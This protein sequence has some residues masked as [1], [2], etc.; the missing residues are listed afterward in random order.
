M[1]SR[2][3][4]P[5]NAELPFHRGPDSALPSTA[6]TTGV[7]PA[8][9]HGCS[10]QVGVGFVPAAHTAEV[11]AVSAGGVDKPAGRTRLA[12]VRG[13]DFDQASA[14][15]LQL[16]AEHGAERRPSGA[17]DLAPESAAHHSLD[18]QL[19]DDHDAVALGVAGRENVENVLALTADL[20]VQRGDAH[21]RPGVAGGALQ[22]TADNAHRSRETTQTSLQVLRILDQRAVG[23]GQQVGHAAVDGDDRT[24]TERGLRKI[25]LALDDGE[26]LVHLTDERASLRDAEE[27]P[28]QD[29][30]DRAQLRE[31]DARRRH[32]ED[33]GVWLGD[34]DDVPP[35]LLPPGTATEPLEVPLPRRIKIHEQLRA[36]IA[37][38]IG[39]PRNLGA[40]FS[41][42]V[43]LVEG[44]GHSRPA[45]QGDQALLVGDVPQGAQPTLPLAQA[46]FLLRRRVDAVAEAPAD[47]HSAP[48]PHMLGALDVPRDRLGRD[49]A[50]R[51]DVEGRRPQ[52]AA[53]KLNPERSE[54]S[55]ERSGRDPLEPLDRQRG[56]NGWRRRKERFFW[57]VN[58]KGGDVTI[59]LTDSLGRSARTSSVSPRSALPHLVWQKGLMVPLPVVAIGRE[60]SL[61]QGPLS[62]RSRGILN[63]TPPHVGVWKSSPEVSPPG[64]RS[65]CDLTSPSRRRRG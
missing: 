36:H 13:G 21:P 57:K 33:P 3:S 7:S 63:D 29:R 32:T 1:D 14:R 40:Q 38:H 5:Y 27:G 18:V 55:K 44:A 16:V 51:A 12:R 61:L 49:L 39:Q 37:R 30:E 46:G 54:F 48:R 65:G 2:V 41:Q 53:S 17:V 8:E 31:H 43:D 34:I 50:R 20:P 28:V 45:P 56:R 25:P 58:G 6:S 60:N 4:A 22:A 47:Q 23:V 64:R 11:F 15:R 62:T 59:R 52:V 26:P 42:L 35:L 10:I 19:L 24:H 9:E